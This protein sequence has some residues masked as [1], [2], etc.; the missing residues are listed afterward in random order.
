[1]FTKLRPLGC[2]F[3]I[4]RGSPGGTGDLP[5][6]EGDLNLHPSGLSPR[7]AARPILSPC[8][9]ER[10]IPGDRVCRATPASC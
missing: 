1:M 2:Q 5:T 4:A 8:A 10:L 7:E 6:E 3:T 9:H